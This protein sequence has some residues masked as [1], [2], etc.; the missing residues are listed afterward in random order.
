MCGQLMCAPELLQ[1]AEET[2]VSVRLHFTVKYFWGTVLNNTWSR[3]SRHTNVGMGLLMLGEC[4]CVW[5]LCAALWALAKL[6][7]S[8]MEGNAS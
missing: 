1:I 7:N 8:E 4:G 3:G 6:W 5:K 2:A